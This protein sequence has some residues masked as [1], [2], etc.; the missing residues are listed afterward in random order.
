MSNSLSGPSIFDAMP[1]VSSTAVK[2]TF[3]WSVWKAIPEISA[4]SIESFS[5]VI[6]VPVPDEKLDRTLTGTLNLFANSTALI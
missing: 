2:V 1:G 4:F 3:V 5:K 6:I